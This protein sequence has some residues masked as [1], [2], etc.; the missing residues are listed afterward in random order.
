VDLERLILPSPRSRNALLRGLRRVWTLPT[1]LVGHAV[2][3]V[4]SRRGPVGVGSSAAR[5]WLYVLEGD[6]IFRRMGAVT[7]GHV[8]I[9]SAACS[10][11]EIGRLVLAHELSHVRQH[12]WLGPLYL[13]LHVLAQLVSAILH[14]IRPVP[15]ESPVHSRNPLEQKF[16]AVPHDLL[17]ACH[18]PFPE[19]VA[20]VLARFGV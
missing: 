20:G 14:V 7:I 1:T 12:D 16:L 2:G 9:S 19:P 18:P 15:D 13:P 10:R 17:R 6:S 4:L 3:L 5:A 11:G 8:V